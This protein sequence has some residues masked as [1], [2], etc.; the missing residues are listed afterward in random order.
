LD[1]LSALP[2][3]QPAELGQL[4]GT[5]DD[6]QQVVAVE[7]PGLAGETDRAVGE[8][9][10]GFADAAGV[11]KEL[12]GRRVARRVLVAKPAF[13]KLIMMIVASIVFC[14]VVHG[15]AD[16]GDLKKVGQVGVK[17]LI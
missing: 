16:A 14:V 7:L 15:I 6:R 10:L 1:R 9:D 4:L 3:G 13:L 12:A 2:Q 11:E 8:Q 17:A 5:L